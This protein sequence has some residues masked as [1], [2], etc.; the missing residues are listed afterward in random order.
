[1]SF[2][3]FQGFRLLRRNIQAG[4]FQFRLSVR[5]PG[6][7]FKFS[8]SIRGVPFRTISPTLNRGC[9]LSTFPETLGESI[10]R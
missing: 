3:G 2:D 5:Q 4:L 1:M 9:T 8:N 10:V 6:A 7:V